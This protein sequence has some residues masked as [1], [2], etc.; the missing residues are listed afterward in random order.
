[1]KKILF[2]I[3]FLFLVPMVFSNGIEIKYC[4]DDNCDWV[5]YG[6]N[7]ENCPE[8]C[9]GVSISNIY[10][11]TRTTSIY[12]TQSPTKNILSLRYLITL[13]VLSITLNFICTIMLIFLIIIFLMGVPK[14][15]RKGEE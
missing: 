10:G 14:Y 15:R 8:D 1:M 11:S 9:S 13:F 7:T 3:L 12:K 4:G 6:E 2:S 5:Y